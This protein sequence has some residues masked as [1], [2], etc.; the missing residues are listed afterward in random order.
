MVAICI[1]LFLGFIGLAQFTASPNALSIISTGL[2]AWALGFGYLAHR[3]R[4]GSLLQ[5]IANDS[6]RETDAI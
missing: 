3:R 2:L 6:L 5:Q 1:A 4:L